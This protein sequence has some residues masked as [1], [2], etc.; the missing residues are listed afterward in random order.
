MGGDAWICEF[1]KTQ[2]VMDTKNKD[3]CYCRKCNNKNQT[4]FEMIEAMQDSEFNQQQKAY[5]DHYH[6]VKDTPSAKSSK[7]QGLDS[8]SQSFSGV[9]H[10]AA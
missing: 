1:C 3:S 8:M 4:I 10:Q 2:N 7:A 6:K 9:R 5:L